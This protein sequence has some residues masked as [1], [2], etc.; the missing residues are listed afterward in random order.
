MISV[1]GS[2]F[3]KSEMIC[4]GFKASF[5]L[6]QVFFDPVHR[7]FERFERIGVCPPWTTG[8]PVTALID[9]PDPIS[10]RSERPDEMT[11]HD[12]V[13][14][15]AMQQQRDAVPCAGFK[16]LERDSIGWNDD[17]ARPKKRRRRRHIWPANAGQLG[18][19]A[20]PDIAAQLSPDSP[21]AAGRAIRDN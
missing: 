20:P 8:R 17:A 9:R 16:N 1:R 13:L 12:G 10:R 18:Q 5:F 2:F 3:D 6:R 19:G 11:P 21:P 4:I 15:K 7:F 14:G